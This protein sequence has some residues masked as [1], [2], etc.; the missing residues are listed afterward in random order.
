VYRSAIAKVFGLLT[1]DEFFF[2]DDDDEDFST[3]E[4]Q[5]GYAKSK[6]IKIGGIPMPVYMMPNGEYRWSMRQASK[7]VGYNE[8]WLRDT[9]QAGGN[10]LVRL[11][12]Y[13]FKGEIVEFSGQ[14]FIESHLI[15]TSDFMAVIMY[16]VLVGYR[17]PAIAL[18]AAAMQETLE[19]RADHAFGV[20]RD[21]DEYIQKFEYRYASIMLNKDLRSEIG[22]W[23]DNNQHSIRE[24]TKQYSIRGGQRGIYATAL[25]EIYQVLFGKCKAQINEFLDIKSYNTPKDHVD[26][27]QLQRITQIEDLAAKYI[28]RKGM[29]PIEAIQA[30]AE[31]LMIDP[32]EPKLGDRITRKDVHR[33]LD[34]KKALS[35]NEGKKKK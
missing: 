13:G 23:I 19:R 29:N 16:A 15:S 5:V 26:V 20:V 10:A 30:A 27:N 17:R 18:M 7:A 14:G 6:E 8:G 4:G 21:E 2:S 25:G 31:A 22:A 35:D 1:F 33:V 3:T 12:G 32:E 28:R 11:K 9:L 34:A 24:Y